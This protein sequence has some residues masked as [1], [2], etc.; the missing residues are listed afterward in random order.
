[1]KAKKTFVV[2]AVVLLMT[3]FFVSASHASQWYWSMNIVKIASGDNG[4]VLT[5]KNAA[6]TVTI[7]K[8]IDPTYANTLL[9]VILTANSLGSP[10]H[11]Y[12]DTGTD[13]ITRVTISN[14]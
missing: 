6:E 13:Y 14:E 8:Y 11:V 3:L 2:L 10:V 1:M 7:Q 9:A 5:V 12:H 4:T